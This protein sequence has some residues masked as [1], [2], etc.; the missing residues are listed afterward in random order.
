MATLQNSFSAPEMRAVWDEKNRL[1][2]Q[3]DA[4]KALALAEGELGLIPAEMA[5]KIAD[6]ANADRFDPQELIELGRTAQHS[7]MPTIQILQRLSGDAGEYVH[8][9]VTTQDIVDTGTMLQLKQADAL[10]EADLKAVMKILYGLVDTY[11]ATP[12][13]GRSH[14]IQGLP[15][16]FGFKLAV[17]LSEMMRNYERLLECR[18]R[19]FVGGMSGAVGTYASFEP[20]GPEVERLAL[21]KLGLGAPEICWQS[22]RDRFSEYAEVI[23]L[24]SGTL[25]RLGNELYNLMRTEFGEVEEPFSKGKIGS[26]TMPHKR[27]PASIE[28]LASLTRPIFHAASLVHESLMM[29]HERDAMSWRAEWIAIPELC[30]YLSCQF[31]LAR[32]ILGGLVV[33]PDRMLRNLNM[34]G[35]LIVS[36]R[37]MFVLGEKI[38]KQTAHHLVYELSMEAE[39]TGTAFADLLASNET[40]RQ[41]LNQDEIAELLNPEHYTGSSVEKA[42]DVLRHFREAGLVSQE[43]L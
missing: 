12:M 29:E 4:E 2:C 43:E 38:G 37:V 20:K 8:Y 9:G 14:G 21:E 40:V 7:L 11:K 22:S 41:Y 6:A 30:Q 17:Y 5:K 18:K 15:I 10:I 35:G 25:G 16:T 34:M 26:S 19:V 3:L 24:I 32:K 13:A 36:E 28:G 1:Q 42:E 27:N 33:K 31:A 23:V 39:E